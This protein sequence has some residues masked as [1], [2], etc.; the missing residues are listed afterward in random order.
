MHLTCGMD[1]ELIMNRIKPRLWQRNRNIVIRLEYNDLTQTGREGLEDLNRLLRLGGG[2]H[3]PSARICR[4]LQHRHIRKVPLSWM[5]PSAANHTRKRLRSSPT[6]EDG[7]VADEESEFAS[8]LEHPLR[9]RLEP[10][11][12]RQIKLIQ[13]VLNQAT[14]CNGGVYVG[15][16]RSCSI[17]I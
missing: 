5:A 12:F 6:S 8:K 13:P 9:Q 17:T 7:E 11:R 15:I 1:L 10:Q 3:R 2:L 14:L 16:S 4:R